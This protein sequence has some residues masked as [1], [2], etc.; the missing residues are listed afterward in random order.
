VQPDGKITTFAG[1]GAEGDSGDGG[2]AK[3]ATLACPSSLAQAPDGSIYVTDEFG[4]LEG[5][6]E[7]G[8]ELQEWLEE[9]SGRVRRIA[10]NGIISTVAG[11]GSEYAQE[12]V[13]QPAWSVMNPRRDRLCL[14]PKGSRSTPSVKCSSATRRPTSW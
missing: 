13:G 7:P 3:E 2:P 14:S 10:P 5:E 8:Q 6:P 9:L 11:G 12:A 1:T 4:G